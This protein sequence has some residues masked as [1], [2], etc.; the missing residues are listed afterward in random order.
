[1]HVAI[2][3]ARGMIGGALAA[4]FRADGH[5]VTGITRSDPGPDELQWSPDDQRIDVDGLRGIDAVVHLAGEPIA[6]SSLTPKGIVEA[7]WSPDRK[8]RIL[9]SRVNGTTLIA[10]T[11]ATMD[12]GPRVMVSASAI[13]Y[14]G[15]RGDDTLTEA[16]APGDLFLS[17]VCQQWE[18]AAEPARAAGIRVVHP[19]I[20]LVQTPDGGALAQSLPLFRLGV[21]GPFGDGSDWWS[22]VMLDDVVGT[23]RHALTTDDLSGPINVTAPEPVTNRTWA[24]VLGRVLGRPAFVPIPRFGPRLAL[25]EMADELL[26]ASARVLPAATTDSGYTFRHPTLETGLRSVL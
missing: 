15:D 5:T 25:G 11:L 6:F 2:T 23:L 13:G 17:H 24:T 19:R 7:R 4:A 26:Y 20:G 1:M 16:S 3:G 8:R 21:G 10:R 18:A 14:Y 9:D 22:W 12:D